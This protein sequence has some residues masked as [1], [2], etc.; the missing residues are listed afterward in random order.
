VASRVVPDGVEGRSAAIPRRRTRA[1]HC[2]QEG[3]ECPVSAGGVIAGTYR[4]SV[5][6]LAVRESTRRI[7]GVAGISFEHMTKRY[8]DG[9]EAVVVLAVGAA[10]SQSASTGPRHSSRHPNG[11]R[12]AEP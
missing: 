8:P 7:N 9:F 1:T 2:E 4:Q 11:D 5:N 10:Y 3:P 12:R 6:A